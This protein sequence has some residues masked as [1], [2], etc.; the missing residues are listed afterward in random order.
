MQLTDKQ[1]EGYQEIYR[2]KFGKEISKE[3]A[4]QQG[5]KLVGLM[6]LICKPLPKK[7]IEK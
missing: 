1:I 6:K 2:K 5:T 4:R 3:A 7:I